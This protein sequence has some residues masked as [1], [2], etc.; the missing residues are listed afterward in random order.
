MR[1]DQLKGEQFERQSGQNTSDQRQPTQIAQA[2]PSAKP[3]D[4]EGEG[5]RRTAIICNRSK[6]QKQAVCLFQPD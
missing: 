3:R 4:E 1:R 5:L 2:L 6:R